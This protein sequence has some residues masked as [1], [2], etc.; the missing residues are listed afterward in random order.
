[1]R[2]ISV[3]NFIAVWIAATVQLNA[4]EL[5]APRTVGMAGAAASIAEG[6]DAFGINPALI[7]QGVNSFSFTCYPF[8]G[9]V[10]P[11]F[12][13]T[14]R[15][16]SAFTNADLDQILTQLGASIPLAIKQYVI[17][18]VTLGGFSARTE[19]T[20]VAGVYAPSAEQSFGFSV[21]QHAAAKYSLMPGLG[22]T[23]HGIAPTGLPVPLFLRNLVA[24][25]GVWYNSYAVSYA[26]S[27]Q[28]A[29]HATDFAVGVSLK[30]IQGLGYVKLNGDLLKTISLGADL[31]G[32]TA[33][34]TSIDYDLRLGSGKFDPLALPANPLYT[35]F[36]PGVGNGVGL[37]FGFMRADEFQG[38]IVKAA[39]S[40]TDIGFINW[41]GS[42]T[43]RSV[44][45]VDTLYTSGQVAVDSL[46]LYVGTALPTAS[47]STPLP[48]KLHLAVSA[49]QPAA[50]GFAPHLISFE[51]TQGVTNIVGN[52]ISPRIA[53]GAEWTS[54]IWRWA[55]GLA[56]NS[57]EHFSWSI[58]G[59]VRLFQ[60]VF[61]D[62]A[63]GR[64]NGIWE[65]PQLVNAVA[66]MIAVF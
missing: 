39:L 14:P 51:Y 10:F 44:H 6:I 65:G 16:A 59:G 48:I 31:I 62:A 20:I 13:L 32:G 21:S 46:K 56:F 63:L 33:I 35:M 60:H 36:P 12:G 50:H 5:G 24:A 22:D 45:R 7:G 64:L 52:S 4:T 3:V 53:A 38:R 25:E 54:T 58:G 41:N 18:G 9:Y 11:L 15:T 28:T 27:P 57:D 34:Q 1:M 23:L 30:Y 55:T 19:G 37:D 49:E 17:D 47:F 26:Y 43:L 66:R 61:L 2:G 8:G 29:N 40:V 42:P